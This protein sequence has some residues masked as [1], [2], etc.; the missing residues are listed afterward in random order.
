VKSSLY[1]SILLMFFLDCFVQNI[2]IVLMDTQGMFDNEATMSLTAR[3]FGLST[4]VSSF[5]VHYA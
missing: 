1:F 2:A 3:I 5:Q 4:L